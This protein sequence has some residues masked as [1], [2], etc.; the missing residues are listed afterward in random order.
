MEQVIHE[1]NRIVFIIF[2]A[3][4]LISGF[5][6][7]SQHSSLVT[8]FIIFGFC[9]VFG[10]LHWRKM[11]IRVLPYFLLVMNMATVATSAGEGGGSSLLTFAL[12]GATLMVYPSVR[13]ILL[14]GIVSLAAVNYF[15][16]VKGVT[17]SAPDPGADILVSNFL[18]L[19]V[20][21]LFT[22]VT[23][24]NVKLFLRSEERTA[25]AE[26]SRIATEDMLRQISEAVQTL[27]AFSHHLK[28]NVRK[29][30]DITQEVSTS[31]SEA[32][33]GVEQQ[34][35][36]VADI[37]ESL[38]HSNDGIQ[39]V[40]RSSQ[41]MRSLSE[42]TASY[43]E[44]GS[45]QVRDLTQRME[46]VDHVMEAI[47]L[48][49][50]RLN[51]QSET[52]AAMLAEITDMANQTNLLALNAAIEASRAGEHGRGFAVV[53]SEVRK[54]AE[55]SRQ[56]AEN[57]STIIQDIRQT[58]GTLTQQI[59]QG[60]GAIGE[61]KQS[62]FR[63]KELFEQIQEN[64]KKVVDQ[65][66]DMQGRTQSVRDASVQIVDEVTSIS[67]VTEQLSASVQQILA[68]MDVQNHQVRDI[69]SSIGQLDELVTELTKLTSAR[70]A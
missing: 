66:A 5:L 8:L 17:Y 1:R 27:Q 19:M 6:I 67:G 57:I 2:A 46:H 7:I 22:L 55:N 49:M 23:Q 47:T 59:G 29:T 69:V 50:D 35:A 9:A 3:I 13:L 45:V 48:S 24:L 58:T 65:A 31:F 70:T 4:T 26:R 33:R 62:V 20:Y 41:D 44:Q 53:S 32:A 39:V 11:M 63:A 18:L 38:H 64:T 25:E 37:N 34:A 51:E 43:T 54:L 28:E 12:G 15:I 56:S 52:I 16:A 40:A 61:S 36:S 10:I 14:Q 21:G 68:S 42:H 60:K 30:G